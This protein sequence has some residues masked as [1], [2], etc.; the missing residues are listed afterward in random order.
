[1]CEKK[2]TKNNS[3]FNIYQL[4]LLNIFQDFV[5]NFSS[6]ALHMRDEPILK[7]ICYGTNHPR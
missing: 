3:N 6:Q 5:K 7:G 4:K 2:R 1:M